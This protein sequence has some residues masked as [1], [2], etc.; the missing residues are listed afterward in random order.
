MQALTEQNLLPSWQKLLFW[1]P[2]AEFCIAPGAPS[3]H[4][5]LLNYF[6]HDQCTCSS[7]PL[8]SSTTLERPSVSHL[9]QLC[10]IVI[11]SQRHKSWRD[12]CNLF[13]YEHYLMSMP[14]K[15]TAQKTDMT[16]ACFTEHFISFLVN[17]VLVAKLLNSPV[18]ASRRCCC[19]SLIQA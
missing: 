2:K 4:H 10:C 7:F 8:L 9:V 5:P 3:I 18:P 14:D 17:R 1:P 12:E 19:C 6:N 13:L 16:R 15:P 11:S